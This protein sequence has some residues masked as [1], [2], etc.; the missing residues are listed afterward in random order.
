MADNEE[1][2][3]ERDLRELKQLMRN[4]VTSHERIRS[5]VLLLRERFYDGEIK[6]TAS[7]WEQW[8][9]GYF[10]YSASYLKRLLNPHPLSS[11]NWEKQQQKDQAKIIHER[12]RIEKERAA[13]ERDEEL[14]RLKEARK[15]A[16]EPIKAKSKPKALPKPAVNVG[17]PPE[18]A[19]PH[20][21]QCTE[22]ERKSRVELGK[23]YAA[24]QE[25]ANKR[26]LGRNPKG[27]P[28]TFKPFCEAYI[29][30]SRQDI[31]K[32]ID[33]YHNQLKVESVASCDTINES[34]VVPLRR[35]GGS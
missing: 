9:I 17:P 5:R 3:W 13:L 19:L 4:E 20:L 33:E 28:W 35:N 15:K 1:L 21:N 12:D 18:A 27:R 16:K 22:I 7:S 2:A 30:R 29:K 32:C 31:Y 11:G 34:S 26:L 6:T 25:L 14:R 24:L 10:A 23:E 8:A